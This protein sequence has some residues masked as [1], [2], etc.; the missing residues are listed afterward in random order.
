MLASRWWVGL[1]LGLALCAC[2]EDTNGL[3]VGVGVDAGPPDSGPAVLG[4]DDG[5]ACTED[6][7][8]DDGT[9]RNQPQD[10]RCPS[11][12]CLRAT[13]QAGVG[14]VSVAEPDGTI[15]ADGPE[16]Q[17]YVCQAGQ[18]A[19]AI[20]PDGRPCVDSDPCTLDDQCRAGT[21]VGRTGGTPAQVLARSF[22]IDQPRAATF[23]HDRLAVE[24]L[25]GGPRLR[26]VARDG[27]RAAP[28][29][30][31]GFSMDGSGRLFHLRDT[32]WARLSSW[33]VTEALNFEWISED[34]VNLV[35]EGGLQIAR[36]PLDAPDLVTYDGGVFFCARDAMEQVRLH[37]ITLGPQGVS[38]VPQVL[39]P[40]GT[41][42]PC[43]APATG[44][45]AG[46]G[47]WWAVWDN[48]A[49]GPQLSVY[50]LTG[51]SAET[52]LN[53]SYA[54]D[55]THQYGGIEGVAVDDDGSVVMAVENPAWLYVMD[56][57]G[58]GVIDTARVDRPAGS[59]LLALRDRKVIFQAGSDLV[60]YDLQDVAAPTSRRIPATLA[61][62]A[63]RVLD[64]DPDRLALVDARGRLHWFE[65]DPVGPYATRIEVRG[66]GSLLDL[67]PMGDQFVGWS[68]RHVMRID[69]RWLIEGGIDNAP[70]GAERPP[71]APLVAVVDGSQSVLLGRG[72]SPVRLACTES[73]PGR[74]AQDEPVTATSLPIFTMA[75][76]GTVLARTLQ[77][78]IGPW[79]ASLARG[80]LALH[81]DVGIKGGSWASTTRFDGARL[82]QASQDWVGIS[83]VEL[84]DAQ[85]DLHPGAFT[86]RF[87][88]QAVLFEQSSNGAVVELGR[89]DVPNVV[90]AA[91]FAPYWYVFVEGNGQE[92]RAVITFEARPNRGLRRLGEQSLG[93]SAEHIVGQDAGLV[94]TYAGDHF[95]VWRPDASGLV[96]V[97]G[98]STVSLPLRV[99]SGGALGTLL[100]RPDGV[101]LLSPSCAE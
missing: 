84:R 2:T 42:D 99:V 9:C 44:G 87:G 38:L 32:R 77:G 101:T 13:C 20:A 45:L 92:Q 82:S 18:C 63:A 34:G 23:V 4:C 81:L 75:P 96:P 91:W 19:Q 49:T 5:I 31:A 52:R 48:S 71:D 61:E 10:S 74:C 12:P 57:G 76:E 47:A 55:G 83:D 60:I 59:R 68:E 79:G 33:G 7:R 21:C 46:L 85:L 17:P 25:A 56:L 6:S 3:G 80:A 8:A 67:A 58:T 64:A 14:C 88:T 26:W 15:C 24:V 30:D 39:L 65:P 36:R 70:V 62:G 28:V 27:A 54:P 50:R 37:G 86:A 69:P 100:V 29:S 16:C 11:D 89:T 66:Q 73:S 97:G 53:F 51:E 72:R 1:G 22:V 43:Q 90:G 78:A 93:G 35:S 41:L 95:S 94:Y 98:F 40:T